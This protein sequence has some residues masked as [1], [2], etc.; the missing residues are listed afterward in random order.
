MMKKILIIIFLLA[1]SLMLKGQDVTGNWYGSLSTPYGSLRLVFSIKY[2]DNAY[3]GTLDSPDQGVSGIPLDT[4]SFEHNVLRIVINQISVEYKGISEADSIKGVFKQR[5]FSFPLDMTRR[6][7]PGPQ[8]PQEPVQPYGYRSEEIK[9]V[10]KRDSIELAG[11]L[12]LPLEKRVY[13]AVILIS[14][15]GPQDR[16]EEIMGHKPFLVMSDYLTRLGLAVLRF[17]DRGVG[18]S[19]GNF[20]KAT[21]MDFA[22]DVEA[23][24]DYLSERSDIQKDKIC[25]L[26]HSEGAAIAPLVAN[27][28]KQVACLVLI[29][30]PV[31]KGSELI[32]AQQEL[33]ARASGV[34]EEDLATYKKLNRA[35]MDIIVNKED[36]CNTEE[37]QKI[38]CDTI[39]AASS[40]VIDEKTAMTQAGQY[41]S[42]WM[43]FFLNYDPAAALRD[44]K[45]PTLAIY[46]S[47]DL[48]V[49]PKMNIEAINK[50]VI[51]P[52]NIITIAELDGLNH[53]LQKAETG[54][55]YEYAKIPET[56][57]PKALNIIGE[58]LLKQIR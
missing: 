30:A 52:N 22:S 32:L 2:S 41:T 23:A 46:G 7:P 55:P 33:I 21:T 43:L 48:Q 42:P 18:E 12:T 20:A 11:T 16:N 26:G 1:E 19:Q 31:I 50:N 53:L 49:P 13:P 56:I 8:R 28:R 35:I 5:G 34:S 27:S 57:S 15:S 6:K 58:W 4:V 51:Q 25:L 17:D 36:G 3:S 47:K 24:V 38:I 10:N 37:L 40:G 54:L 9:F 45:S 39:I 29:G 44:V 14:G